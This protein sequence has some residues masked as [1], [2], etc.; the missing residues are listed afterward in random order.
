MTTLTYLTTNLSIAFRSPSG[1]NPFKNGCISSGRHW[2]RVRNR[3]VNRCAGSVGREE[4]LNGIRWGCLV[5]VVFRGSRRR[6]SPYEWNRVSARVGKREE[7]DV[8]RVRRGRRHVR[9][10]LRPVPST[11]SRTHPSSAARA[12]AQL[13]AITLGQPRR[14]THTFERE[15]PLSDLF[16]D[17]LQISR[18]HLVRRVL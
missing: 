4:T 12:P 13:S 10:P 1:V 18:P 9:I 8:P 11:S 2:A 7:G 17:P 5:N 3:S 6:Y 15:Q 14:G 16:D